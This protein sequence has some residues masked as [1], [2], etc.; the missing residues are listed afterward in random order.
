MQRRA[1]HMAGVICCDNNPKIFVRQRSYYSIVQTV[2]KVRR[3]ILIVSEQSNQIKKAKIM[4]VFCCRLYSH[5][6][7]F[8]LEISG[9]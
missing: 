9:V 2:G 5:Q 4:E 6:D 1:G 8:L 7:L 3:I